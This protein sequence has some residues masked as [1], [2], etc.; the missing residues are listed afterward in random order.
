[1]S[2]EFKSSQGNIARPQ[3]LIFFNLLFLVITICQLQELFPVLCVL[4]S[5]N[6]RLVT[7]LRA[8]GRYTE[9]ENFLLPSHGL[10][11]LVLKQD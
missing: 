11:Q 7:L 10:L 5:G 4:L 1:M 9:V 6:D 2:Q 3:S 8:T